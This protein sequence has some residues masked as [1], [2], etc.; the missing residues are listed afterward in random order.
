MSGDLMSTSVANPVTSQLTAPNQFVEAANGIHYAY[1]RFGGHASGAVPL[2]FLQHFRGDIDNWD[3]A[4]ID[5]IA[6]DREV[7][8]FD[9][10]GVGL[11]SGQ[12]P[13][14]I[15]QMA[16]DAIAFLAALELR[17]VDL[18]GF[19][20]GGFVAQ[21]VV[22]IRPRLVRRLV[23]A[24]TGP[25][26]ALGMHGWRPD[27][28]EHA[29]RAQPQG[30]DLLHIFFA[31]TETSQAVGVEFLGRLMRRTENRDTGATPATSDA[32]YDAIVEWGIPDALAVQRLTAIRQPT[33]IVQ[34][35]DDLMIPTKG[36]HLMAALLPDAQLR[37]Y[38]DAAHASIFQYPI[39][40]AADVHRFL[41]DEAAA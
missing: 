4:L 20:L 40:V 26:G 11:S 12:T 10:T 39:E 33:L 24:G 15:G 3:H 27:I 19:S 18:F 38:P 21:E 13:S 25:K 9:N 35:D 31:H 1:R 22:L 32:Q 28:E 14:S 8:L 2:V 23:L 5:A 7:I 41:S 37:I 30:E 29:R 34:G 36:S 16:R 6:A 17:E